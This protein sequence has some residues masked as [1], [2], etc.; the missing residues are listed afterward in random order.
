MYFILVFGLFTV[1]FLF[2]RTNALYFRL[3][4]IPSN[5]RQQLLSFIS[6]GDFLGAQN[7]A[8]NTAI[9]C[10]SGLARIAALGC[11]LRANGA[12]DD[13]VQARMDEALSREISTLDKRTGFLG[14]FGNVATLLGLL[15]TIAGMIT[16]FAA[17][18]SASPADRATMLSMGISEAMNC[19]AFGL[20]V[21]I[22]A[23]VCF[24]I[25]QNRT[26]KV[27]SSL[28]EGAT[29][30]FNDLIF[31]TESDRAMAGVNQDNRNGLGNRS[32][33]MAN[34]HPAPNLSV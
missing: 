33:A 31:L 8:Q 16:S 30:I 19:T 3:K 2:E 21:A 17:V 18:A 27:V 23:L 15:G 32:A 14:M 34:R 25:F 10:N 20:I 12:G 4:A 5:F 1:A 29:E 26:D 28:T 22:P 7:F 11:Q 9:G 24:A 13:E 6:K